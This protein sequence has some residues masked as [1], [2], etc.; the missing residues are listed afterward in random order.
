MNRFLSTLMLSLIATTVLAQQPPSRSD[1]PIE[2][3]S[4][5]GTGKSSQTPDRFSFTAGVVTVS[6]TV[7]EAVNQNNAKVARVV[8]ALK[9]AGATDQQIRT[10]NFSVSPQ[11]DYSQN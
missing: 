11:Q 5:G 3:I 10:S 8:E 1:A 9:K 2:T 7:D 4:V 6:P